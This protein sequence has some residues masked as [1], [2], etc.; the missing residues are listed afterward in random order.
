MAWTIGCAGAEHAGAGL[1]P[2]DD[3]GAPDVDPG[4]DLVNSISD[5]P[6]ESSLA[7]TGSACLRSTDCTSDNCVEGICCNSPCTGMCVTCAAP[8]NLGRCQPAPVGSDPRNDCP[9]EGLLSCGRDGFCDG[10]GGCRRY[11]AGAICHQPTCA[12]TSL[13]T[14]AL[15]DGTGTC[16]IAAE[17][18]CAPFL[19]GADQMCKSSC[20]TDADC[21][22]PNTCQAGTCGH[23]APGSA[24]AASSECASGVCAQGVCCNAA[25]DGVCRSCALG[26]S[27]GTCS[28]IPASQQSMGSC[29]MPAICAAGAC[30]GLVGTYF[31]MEDFTDQALART[32]ATVDFDWGQASPDPRVPIDGFSIRWTGT[33][34]PRFSETYTFYTLADDGTRL[35]IN[36]QQ[37]INDWAVHPAAQQSGSIPLQA[38]KPVSLRL[39]YFDDGGAALVHLSW[40]SASE[41]KAIIPTSALHP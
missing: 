25:C 23:R 35:W 9:D 37:L 34:T 27:R 20:A 28:N 10:A 39:E 6:I 15:C 12:G 36:G 18:S 32:D 41:P 38:G 8:G 5:A 40:S 11:P 31:N 4:S 14:A 17:Q 26:S 30:G 29:A 2:P 3:A 33:V 7:G 24:C 16:L 13:T 22:A 19:C 21:L 1:L